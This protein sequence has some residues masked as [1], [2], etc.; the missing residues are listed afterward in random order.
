[1]NNLPND[2]KI[3]ILLAIILMVVVVI[4]LVFTMVLYSR[5]QVLFEKEKELR[6]LEYEKQILQKEVDF[7]KKTKIEEERI[8]HDLHDD[9]GSGIT[10][11]KLQVEFLKKKTTDINIG[12]YVEEILETCNQLHVSVRQILWNLKVGDEDLENFTQRTS[13]YTKSFFA[14]TNIEV[15]ICKTSITQDQISAD[16]RRNIFLCL[17]E[18]LNNVYKH[19]KCTNVQVNYTQDENIF[20]IDIKDNGIGLKKSAKFGYGMENM[21]SRMAALNGE[22]TIVPLEKG[23]H[24]QMSINLDGEKRKLSS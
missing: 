14:K 22:F 7:Q 5:K 17:K 6:N 4:F 1:M 24:L 21:K 12:P 11:L 13:Q 2:I 16:T 19:S 9:V 10:A 3:T 18:A 23:L 15:Q 20:I 8:S